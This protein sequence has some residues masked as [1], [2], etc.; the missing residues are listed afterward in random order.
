MRTTSTKVGQFRMSTNSLMQKMAPA[1]KSNKVADEHV[2]PVKQMSVR[3][4]R[5]GQT[6]SP[7][8]LTSYRNDKLRTL[9]SQYSK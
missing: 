4:V 2:V 8:Q 9:L 6:F 5:K 3:V 1:R 7:E